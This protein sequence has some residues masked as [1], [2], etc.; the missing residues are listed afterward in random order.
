MGTFHGN[1]CSG[2]TQKD[3]LSDTKTARSWFV[4]RHLEEVIV[5]NGGD[6]SA[7]QNRSSPGSAERAPP[8]SN[9][10]CEERMG[11][12]SGNAMQ[13]DEKVRH[14]AEKRRNFHTFEFPG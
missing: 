7:S 2:S 4:K 3:V 13:I 14:P 11:Q 9:G 6:D 10:P 5:G 1:A 12:R 8:A